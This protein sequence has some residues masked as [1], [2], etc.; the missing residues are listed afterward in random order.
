MKIILEKRART[1]PILFEKMPTK[2]FANF[3]R[4]CRKDIRESFSCSLPAQAEYGNNR[5]R[6]NNGKRNTELQQCHPHYVYVYH[7]HHHHHTHFHY[8]LVIDRFSPSLHPN[9]LSYILHCQPGNT[10]D[11]HSLQSRRE[12]EK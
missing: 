6:A 3:P 2:L 1:I 10:T 8:H 7:H 5:W 4:K 12:I 11:H 9:P